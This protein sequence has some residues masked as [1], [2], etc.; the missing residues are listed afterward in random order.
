LAES[1]QGVAKLDCVEP[2]LRVELRAVD[3][4]GHLEMVV[5]ITP[6]H[7]SQKHRFSIGVDQSYLNG[8]IGSLD[9]IL[10]SRRS[11]GLR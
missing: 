1:L 6:D 2:E 7:L 3:R 4:L 11:G 8:L 5:D 9:D 10:A